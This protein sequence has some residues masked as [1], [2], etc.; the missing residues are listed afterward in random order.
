MVYSR[1][2]TN[3][4]TVSMMSAVHSIYVEWCLDEADHVLCFQ[5]FNDLFEQINEC[6][7][8]LD[9]WQRTARSEQDMNEEASH[10]AAMLKQ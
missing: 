2:L 9:S 3:F 6:E 7:S 5:Y 4:N 8:S 10:L 1:Q